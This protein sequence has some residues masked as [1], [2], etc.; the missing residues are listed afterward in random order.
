MAKNK[1]LSN[2]RFD[3][4]KT[5]FTVQIPIKRYRKIHSSIAYG[6]VVSRHKKTTDPKKR[7][8]LVCNADYFIT[9]HQNHV[10]VQFS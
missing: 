10:K 9:I 6:F 3:F 8:I 2:C 7:T 5:F 4:F 1:F